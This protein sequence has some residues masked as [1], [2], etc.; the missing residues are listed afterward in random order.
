MQA[1]ELNYLYNESTIFK[2]E[3]RRDGVSQPVFGA[4]RAGS[5]LG[6]SV[7]VSF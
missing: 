2:L 7:V 6:A 5:L 4:Y 3:Y 1:F